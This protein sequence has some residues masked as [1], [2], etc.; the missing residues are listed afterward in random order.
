V[1]WDFA[2]AVS[3]GSRADLERAVAL[4]PLPDAIEGALRLAPAGVAG[5]AWSRRVLCTPNF[6]HTVM[7]EPGAAANDYL[8]QPEA[9]LVLPPTSPR[10]RCARIAACSRLC[11][12]LGWLGKGPSALHFLPTEAARDRRCAPS[13]APGRRWPPDAL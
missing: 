5:L 9:M 7:L 3:A 1:D 4:L 11:A 2:A 8:R 6:L 13:A 12:L 10:Q